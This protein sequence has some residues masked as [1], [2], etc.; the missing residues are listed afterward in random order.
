MAELRDTLAPG[1]KLKSSRREY[2][3]E[4]MLGR[5][6][7]GITYRAS[8]PITDGN[9]NARAIVAIKE[10]FPLDYSERKG[11]DITP[12]GNNAEMYQRSLS[13]FKAEAERLHKLG[14]KHPNIVGVNEVF[15][16]NG[17]AYYVMEYV[18]GKSL[19]QYIPK[20]GRLSEEKAL[21]IL[22]PVIDAIGYLHN[23]RVTHLDVKPENIMLHAENEEEN[24]F[25]PVLIDFGLSMHYDSKGNKTRSRGTLG[26]SDGYSPMEQYLGISTF[27]PTADIYALGATL[28]HML[29]GKRPAV[30]AELRVNAVAAELREIGISETVINALVHALRYQ[31]ED[32][33]PDVATLKKELGL[34]ST[35]KSNTV[36][37]SKQKEKKSNTTP[38]THR[39]PIDKRMLTIV[40]A[41]VAV[42]AV[43]GG[44][45]WHFYPKN[46]SS[47]EIVNSNDSH[48]KIAQAT[49][50]ASQTVI[51]ETPAQPAKD[52]N[53]DSGKQPKNDDNNAQHTTPNNRNIKQPTQP[54]NQDNNQNSEFIEIPKEEKPA[55]ITNG[56]YSFSYGTYTGQLK[57]GKPDGYG[58]LTYSS[59]RT[60]SGVKVEAGYTLRGTWQNGRTVSGKIYDASGK[61][62]GTY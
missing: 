3:I 45:V 61:S 2:K 57:N 38:L 48:K 62:L 19:I 56:T 59:S 52:D 29:T 5:G 46:E 44:A 26:A 35:A 50:T 20:G 54:G 28:L 33:T 23:N 14:A 12:V 34:A 21:H 24:E 1:F 8:Y 47:E 17:T 27:T 16:A 41:C 32:R 37:L 43:V 7:F 22:E 4:S 6:G 36:F 30:A 39:K 15:A 31:P 10:H 60:V 53:D 25:T 11:A 9:I 49:D 18:E 42:L 40:A 55:P 51:P 13:D 58:T